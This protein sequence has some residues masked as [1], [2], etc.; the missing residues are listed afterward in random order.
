M[1]LKSPLWAL[2][3]GIGSVWVILVITAIQLTPGQL[4]VPM[5]KNLRMRRNS[6]YNFT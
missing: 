2:S 4:A 5:A 6:T 3:S 1:K